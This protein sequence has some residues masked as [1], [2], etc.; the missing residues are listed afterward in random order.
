MKDRV[1]E[2]GGGY[3]KNSVTAL[4]GNVK[5]TELP[6]LNVGRMRHACGH[7]RRRGGNIVSRKTL[8]KKTEYCLFLKQFQDIL[9]VAGGVDSSGYYIG[10]TE[11]LD[12]SGAWR[13]VSSELHPSVKLMAFKSISINNHIFITGCTYIVVLNAK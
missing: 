13:I 7:Y 2:T 4:D 6:S 3:R 10:S 12:Q 8:T 9:L 5:P 1:I 11:I